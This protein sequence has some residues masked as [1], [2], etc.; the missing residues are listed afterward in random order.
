MD[1]PVLQL[2]WAADEQAAAE[3]NYAKKAFAGDQ[4]RR[5]RVAVDIDAFH[6][7]TV[8]NDDLGGL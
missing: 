7:A 2:S 1:R 8:F 3:R 4:S 5:E 6:A